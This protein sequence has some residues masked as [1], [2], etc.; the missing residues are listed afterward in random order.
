MRGCPEALFDL[1]LARNIRLGGGRTFQIR[2]E[3]Y[4][5]FNTVIFNGRNTTMNI[6]SLAT[7]SVATNLPYDDGRQSHRQPDRAEHLGFRRGDRVGC[8]R[9]RRS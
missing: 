6:A 4:N 8:C 5:V 2:V 9:G 3:A 1:A 7:A